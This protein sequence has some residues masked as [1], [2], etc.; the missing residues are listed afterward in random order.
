MNAKTGVWQIRKN[1]SARGVSKSAQMDPFGLRNLPLD[2]AVTPEQYDVFY[3]NMAPALE[4]LRA[5]GA[6]PIRTLPVNSNAASGN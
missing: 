5:I 2:A 6:L 1:N 4:L 3:T